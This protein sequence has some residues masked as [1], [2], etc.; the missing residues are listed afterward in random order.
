MARDKTLKGPF[1][2]SFQFLQVP[3]YHGS[4]GIEFSAFS[5]LQIVL[6]HP[7]DFFQRYDEEVESD[8][9]STFILFFLLLTG[10]S[11]R[12]IHVK[13]DFVALYSHSSIQQHSM[14]RKKMRC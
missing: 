13:D 2:F 7:E 6:F 11:L 3:G 10:I 9:E 12:F 4:M 5:A 1:E 14:K 8:S